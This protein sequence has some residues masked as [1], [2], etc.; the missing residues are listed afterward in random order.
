MNPET[1]HVAI[2]FGNF[3]G[4][5]VESEGGSDAGVDTSDYVYDDAADDAHD[6]DEHMEVD[7]K[8]CV[9]FALLTGGLR[10]AN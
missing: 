1:N 3:I 10:G 5:E 4:E 2:R 9:L 7:G 8:F 6:E